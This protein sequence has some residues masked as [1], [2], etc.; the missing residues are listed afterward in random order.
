MKRSLSITSVAL[1]VVLVS[2]AVWWLQRAPEPPP[3]F[4][5]TQQ[6]ANLRVTLQLDDTALGERTINI[7]LQDANGA[8]VDA[9]SV[10]LRFSMAE[11]DMGT[12]EAEAERV[13]TGHYRVTGNFFTMV[14]RWNVAATVQ[15]SDTAPRTLA[16]ALPVAA[17]GEAS[18]PIN[19]F[20][21][22]EATL[23]AARP[24]YA[25]NCATCHGETGQGD[26]P[27]AMLLRPEP[28]D[29]TQ[30]MQVGKHTDGQ[31]FLWIRDGFPNSAMPAWGKQ[32]SDEQIWQLVA[33][34]RS[35]G[36]EANLANTSVTSVPTAQPTAQ[37]TVVAQTNNPLPPLILVR[38]GN[39]WQSDGKEAELRQLTSLGDGAYAEY[40]TLSPD[41]K[42]IAFITTSQPPLKEGDW[43]VEKPQTDLSVVDA[44]GSNLRTIWK[45]DAGILGLTAWSPDGAAIYVGHYEIKSAPGAPVATRIIQI[46]RVDV[47]TGAHE[48]ALENA[49]DPTF[50]ADGKQMAFLRWH[51]DLA[52][53]TLNVAAPDGSNE[54]EVTSWSMFPNMYAPR[55]SPDGRQLIFASSGGPPVDEQGN[56]IRSSGLLS[57]IAGLFAPGVAEAHGAASEIWIIGVD[58]SGL[59]RLTTLSEDTPMAIFA[60]DGKT[61][62]V[63]GS[64]GI[65][66]LNVD[67]SDPRKIDEK[68]DH[69]GLDWGQR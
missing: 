55:F 69:G 6:D 61:I 50:S 16:F 25:A 10:R 38:E 1:L 17:P 28:S 18:G 56:P 35:F 40:P 67:G 68:G 2:V 32:F 4:T 29:F 20:V 57:G 37:P 59:R 26:G 65:Y 23:A 21:A 47:A 64:G 58:G 54:R 60:S 41:G 53:F 42:Q 5:Q 62:V 46:V 27:T 63:M 14:G 9:Q 39:L 22:D 7:L 30:H 12:L 8:A 44:N 31:V 13:A 45:P 66:Q 3:A 48:V 49:Y 43:P 15:T 24:L 36:Q 33:L 52:A 51:D 11:M 34:L 19:P